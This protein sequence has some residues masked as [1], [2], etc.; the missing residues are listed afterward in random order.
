MMQSPENRSKAVLSGR[1]RELYFL[2][3][4]KYC[5]HTLAEKILHHGTP[6]YHASRMTHFELGLIG[7][8]KS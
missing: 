5:Y 2:G 1:E 6:S 3:E 8:A 7:H 4:T